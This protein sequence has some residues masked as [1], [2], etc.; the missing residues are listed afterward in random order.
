MTLI[1]E[2]YFMNGS[3]YLL[4]IVVSCIDICLLRETL[5]HAS[6]AD[7]PRN[8]HRG[9]VWSLIGHCRRLAK[10]NLLIFLKFFLLYL[11]ENEPFHEIMALIA[12]RKLNLQTRMHSHL[13]GLHVWFSV[14]SFVC[15]YSL[16]VR[17][18]MALVRLR[19]CAGSPEPSLFAYAISTIISW[20]GSNM[21]GFILLG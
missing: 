20:A 11:Y 10:E 8:Q 15:F 13:M 14:R 17:T 2:L 18:A 12:L 4:I 9:N 21:F 3:I 19:E 6:G 5:F 7:F 1:C 16:C